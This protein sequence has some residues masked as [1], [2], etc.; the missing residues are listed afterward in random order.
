LNS[1]NY[2]LFLRDRKTCSTLP[3][4][5]S[6]SNKL[7]LTMLNFNFWVYLLLLFKA[8]L[9]SNYGYIVQYIDRKSAMYCTPHFSDVE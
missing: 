7:S 1:H 3:R 8:A 6:F 9:C 2:F 4:L 5:M